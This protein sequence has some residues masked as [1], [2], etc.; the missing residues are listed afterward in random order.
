LNAAPAAASSWLACCRCKSESESE[1]CEE[2]E[3]K[4]ES[5]SEECGESGWLVA[6]WDRGGGVPSI[7]GLVYGIDH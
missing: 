3:S 6:A 7:V 1:E 4:S 2:S 5:E